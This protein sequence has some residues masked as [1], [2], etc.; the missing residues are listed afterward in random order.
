MSIALDKFDTNLV[1]EI[2]NLHK[3]V[4]YFVFYTNI[5]NFIYSDIIITLKQIISKLH[6]TFYLYDL[7]WV[8]GNNYRLTLTTIGKIEELFKLQAQDLLCDEE[9]NECCKKL[10][11]L[12]RLGTWNY[13]PI[14]YNKP[15]YSRVDHNGFS[16]SWLFPM[17]LCSV[18]AKGHFYLST[19][20]YFTNIDKRVNKIMNFLNIKYLE[21]QNNNEIV[22]NSRSITLL[23]KI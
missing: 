23:E 2:I 13:R 21:G 10:P 6:K 1:I 4:D 17:L 19:E 16:L 5:S 8:R 11:K 22:R 20:V 7:S 9:I 14:I 15:Y 18:N 12:I 3:D